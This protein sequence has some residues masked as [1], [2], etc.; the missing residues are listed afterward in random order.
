MKDRLSI[1]DVG[2]LKGRWEFNLESGKLNL[3]ESRNSGGKTS[4]VRAL[5]AVLS[6]PDDRDLGKFAYNE[7]IKVFE[8]EKLP[9]LYDKV[10]ENLRMCLLFCR[11][12]EL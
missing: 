10:Q 9:E 2:G 8:E 6:M 5:V 1:Q 7:A 3:L 11:E 12:N 4:A